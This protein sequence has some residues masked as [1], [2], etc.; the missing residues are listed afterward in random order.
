MN[1]PCEVNK[2]RNIQSLTFTW[3][4][5]G[6]RV[7]RD[8]KQGRMSIR[9]EDGKRSSLTITNVTKQDSGVYKC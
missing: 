6:V 8:K 7:N 3:S 9:K 5:N 4:R 2:E 1:I